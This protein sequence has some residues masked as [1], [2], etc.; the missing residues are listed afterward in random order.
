MVPPGKTGNLEQRVG[1]VIVVVPAIRLTRIG[2]AAVIMQHRG[3]R[4]VMQ[5]EERTE[6]MAH[7]DR[8]V[9][10]LRSRLQSYLM[11]S[12]YPL[13]VAKGEMEAV[14]A[15]VVRGDQAAMEEKVTRVELALEILPLVESVGLEETF[16]L[17]E[18]VPVAA[19]VDSLPS[20]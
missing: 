9:V 14:V 8:M 6:Q 18:R 20:S 2:T 12:K 10:P 1:P 17:A 5:P 19:T 11:G 16:D 4:E 7:P 3:R 15:M 13:S